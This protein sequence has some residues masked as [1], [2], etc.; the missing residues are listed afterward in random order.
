MAMTS[1]SNAGSHQLSFLFDFE[2]EV[3]LGAT[4]SVAVNKPVT[5]EMPVPCVLADAPLTKPEKVKSVFDLFFSSLAIR[6]E[7]RGKEIPPAE[8]IRKFDPDDFPN[9]GENDFEWTDQEI[10]LLHMALLD[11]SVDTFNAKRPSGRKSKVEALRWIFGEPEI[12]SVRESIVLG[13]KV[14]RH[15][16]TQ[17]I[18]FTFYCACHLTGHDPE[19]IQSSMESLLRST[20]ELFL[21][22]EI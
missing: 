10:R 6:E 19:V 13:R 4:D 3:P 20:D 5:L 12:H 7:M 14:K 2:P 18:P 16:L 9:I 8:V 1:S 21:L 11:W 17:S 15:V 22:E